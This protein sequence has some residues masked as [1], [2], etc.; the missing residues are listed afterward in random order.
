M[1]QLICSSLFCIRVFVGCLSQV[2]CSACPFL[3]KCSC[4]P[5]VRAQEFNNT[6]HAFEIK[7]TRDSVLEV[8]PE[9]G[10]TQA[11]PTARFNVRAG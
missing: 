11:I 10:D 8:C 9:D 1:A 4:A 3:L 5:D 7:M 6:N 2:A